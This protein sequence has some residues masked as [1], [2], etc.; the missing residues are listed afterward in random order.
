MKT[1]II[2]GPQGSG[3]TTKAIELSKGKLTLFTNLNDF[4]RN[5]KLSKKYAMSEIVVFDEVTENDVGKLSALQI[6]LGIG[7]IVLN[8]EKF[9]P[10]DLILITQDSK[11]ADR[12]T[13]TTLITLP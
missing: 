2:C 9:I 1:T 4:K 10:P 11:L 13:C 3:K 6:I 12:L 5:V 8:T 7:G